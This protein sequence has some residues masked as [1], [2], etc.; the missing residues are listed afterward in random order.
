MWEKLESLRRKPLRG[1]CASVLE[2]FVSEN[3]QGNGYGK[4]LMQKFEALSQSRGHDLFM[5]DRGGNNE[6]KLN[7]FYGGLGYESV[8]PDNPYTE[9]L[10]CQWV[11]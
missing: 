1:L 2:L 3:A 4:A 8:E 9:H 11:S 10:L 5:V 6:E 7:G